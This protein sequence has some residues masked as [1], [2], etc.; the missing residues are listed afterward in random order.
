M[1]G[2]GVVLG[3]TKYDDL[4]CHMAPQYSINDNYTIIYYF[5]YVF[6]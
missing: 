4:R 3:F 6:K 2:L 1:K 5:I